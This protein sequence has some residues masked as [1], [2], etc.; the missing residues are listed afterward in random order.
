MAVDRYLM[1]ENIVTA[2]RRK[3]LRHIMMASGG[4]HC[5]CRRYGCRGCGKAYEL[6]GHLASGCLGLG[7]L[8]AESVGSVGS[9]R[10]GG[11]RGVARL[12][13]GKCLA[14]EETG[15]YKSTKDSRYPHHGPPV[16]TG[17]CKLQ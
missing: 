14:W 16:T 5:A 8:K 10:S 17:H 3:S 4:A 6:L 11:G 15:D 12:G 9:G 13:T 7:G 2:S 1:A